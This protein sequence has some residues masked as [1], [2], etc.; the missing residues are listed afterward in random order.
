MKKRFLLLVTAFVFLA[1]SSASALVLNFN[2][3][4]FNPDGADASVDY[5]TFS[6][7]DQITILG[8][9][10]INGAVQDPATLSGTF[11]EYG[12]F[13]ATGFQNNTIPISD[14][15]TGLGDPTGGYELTF[16]MFDT[17]GTFVYNPISNQNDLLFTKSKFNIYLDVS[18]D[19]G[20]TTGALDTFGANNGVLIAAFEL[21]AGTGT[22]NFGAATGPDGSTDLLYQARAGVAGLTNGLK[23][24][25]WFTKEGIDMSTLSPDL[26]VMSVVDTNN[27]IMDAGGSSPVST[28]AL[29]G[30]LNGKDTLVSGR[31]NPAAGAFNDKFFVQ[32]DGSLGLAAIPE[33]ATMLL[34]GFGL[35]GLAAV[36]RK[37]QA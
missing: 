37:R 17:A 33:P 29:F 27:E 35:M 14:F 36:G 4:K 32:S 3:W 18:Q 1:A 26:I 28:D 10:L 31:Y 5:S 16:E 34:F 6:P 23:A 22:M 21:I 20:S 25:V 2:D 11:K 15:T 19:Y 24:G 12:V 9:A 30:E 13:A 7:I 8:N